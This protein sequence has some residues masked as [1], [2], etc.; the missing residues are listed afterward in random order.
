[1]KSICPSFHTAYQLCAACFQFQLEGVCECERWGHSGVSWQGLHNCSN[2]CTTSWSIS[3]I[4]C[5][6][7]AIC[8]C[9]SRDEC[10]WKSRVWFKYQHYLLKDKCSLPT[11][12]L[13]FTDWCVQAFLLFSGWEEA[14][15]FFH[16]KTSAGGSDKYTL[17][18]DLWCYDCDVSA[19]SHYLTQEAPRQR[20]FQDVFTVWQL[21]CCLPLDW[22]WPLLSVWVVL[23]VYV[24]VGER[25]WYKCHNDRET[26]HDMNLTLLFALLGSAQLTAC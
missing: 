7:S 18:P 19:K 5:Q 1:M 3:L 10:L 12:V 15:C 4:S 2:G 8:F 14:H 9:S 20:P 11:S 26:S 23:C 22:W 17:S 24:G 6:P 16:C 13:L 21:Y 25:N